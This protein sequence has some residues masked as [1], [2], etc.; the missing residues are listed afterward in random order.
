M[1]VILVVDGDNEVDYGCEEREYESEA[2]D[3]H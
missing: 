1:R 3:D 2:N